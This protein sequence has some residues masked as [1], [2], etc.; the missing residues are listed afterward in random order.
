[1]FAVA[2][3]D[4]ELRLNNKNLPVAKSGIRFEPLTQGSEARK[5]LAIFIKSEILA[6]SNRYKHTLE[7]LRT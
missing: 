2:I 6:I 1:M 4:L 3:E 7:D 5:D